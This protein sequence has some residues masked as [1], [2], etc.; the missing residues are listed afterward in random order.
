[1]ELRSRPTNVVGERFYIYAA[2]T[3]LAVARGRWP[4]WSNDLAGA[5]PPPP[6]WM[7]ELA[8]QVGM[9]EPGA[10]ER[11]PRGVIVGTAVIEW[12][13]SVDGGQLNVEVE[14]VDGGLLNVEG[15][16]A[17]PF[18]QSTVDRL[19][20]APGGCRAGPGNTPQADRAAAAGVV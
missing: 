14:S 16:R 1:V 11:L 12:V 3:K 17:T 13:E 6:R 20:L 10:I 4:A 15:R 9:I 8:E 5:R 7:I 19:R 18:Q 2:K